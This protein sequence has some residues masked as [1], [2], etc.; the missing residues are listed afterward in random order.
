VNRGMSLVLSRATIADQC[1]PPYSMT[2]PNREI[3][4]V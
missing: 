1:I 2:N 4:I 3:E